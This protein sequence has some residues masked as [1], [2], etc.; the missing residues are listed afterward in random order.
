MKHN[1]IS[2]SK[3]DGIENGV[4]APT[5]SIRMFTEVYRLPWRFKIQVRY[6][7]FSTKLH[8]PKAAW[9]RALQILPIFLLPPSNL[10]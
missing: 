7:F 4:P 8:L 1:D 2:K 5:Y 10:P 6:A 9:S 3:E